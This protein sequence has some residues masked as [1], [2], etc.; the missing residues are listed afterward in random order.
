M[1]DNKEAKRL[2]E[3]NFGSKHRIAEAYLSKLRL[4][5]KI[6]RDNPCSLQELSLFLIECKN[7][8]L[9]PIST[10]RQELNSTANIRTVVAKLYLIICRI[11][12]EYSSVQN[13][14]KAGKNVNLGVTR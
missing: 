7:A 10:T 8:S 4:R 13:R 12:G 14:R 5:P 1:N 9:Y 6:T 3:R 2:L 11:S